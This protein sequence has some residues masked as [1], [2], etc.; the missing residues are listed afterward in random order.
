MVLW[1]FSIKAILQRPGRATLTLLSIVIG[2][3]ILVSVA[4]ATTTTR[5]AY[6]DMF[7]A[8]SGRSAL[9]VTAEGGGSFEEDLVTI[10]R[11]TPGVEAAVPVIRRMSKGFTEGR[12]ASVLVLGID[13][14]VDGA[15]RDLGVTARQSHLQEDGVLLEADFARGLGVDVGDKMRLLGRRGMMKL[16]VQGLASSQLHLASI[17]YVRLETAQALFGMPSEITAIQVVVEAGA[18][19][20][21]V[22]QAIAQRLPVGISVRPPATRTQLA[23]ETMLSAETGLKMTTGFSL[24]LA[25][26]VILNT[27]LM[28]VAERRRQLSMMRAIGATRG[29]ISRLIYLEG[30][31]IASVGVVLGILAGLG[32]GHLLILAL[33]KALLVTLPP[34]QLSWLTIVLAG[35]FGLGIAVLGAAIPARRAAQLSPQEGMVGAATRGDV[36]TPALKSAIPGALMILIALLLLL[37]CFRNW[38]PPEIAVGTSLL[39]LLGMVLLLSSWLDPLARFGV[40][41]LTPLVRAE[42]NL[43][44]RQ[45][46]RHRARSALTMGVLFV[47][48]ATGVG[49]S[50]ALLDNIQ[51]VANW[52]RQVIVGDFF[53]RA[54]LPDMSGN[55][56]ADVPASA[57]D[58]ARRVPGVRQVG[59]TTFLP[60][61]VADASVM[62]I[63]REFADDDPLYLDLKTGSD[64]SVRQELR[65]G[66]VVIGT[67]LAQRTGL[68][69][70]DD[71]ELKTRDG[72]RTVRIAGTANDYLFGGLTV[73]LQRRVAEDWFKVDNVSSFVVRLDK[74]T[75]EN[76]EALADTR[77]RLSAICQRHG[78]MLESQAELTGM[79]DRMVAGV[80]ACLYGILVLG[81]IVAAFGTVNTL[82]MNV[83]E[84]TRELGLLRIVAMTRGQIRKTILAQAVILAAIGLVPGVCAG[85][86]VSYLISIGTAPATGHPIEFQWHPAL[87][88]V[89]LI[90]SLA[91]VL[92]AAWIPAERAA[93]LRLLEA[94]QYE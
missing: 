5:A 18:D 3:A 48:S 45:V 73:C 90:A 94:L 63:V 32:G 11:Q 43:A 8:V 2:V 85:V 87:L 41:L 55:L 64:K 24:L 91:I 66:Q 88:V 27:F 62:V 6:R 14:D 22:R 49:M 89:S 67:V 21:A 65:D 75:R 31:G 72:T 42:A 60:A 10:V 51:D 74:E 25:M 33:S 38:L 26:F 79:I 50:S 36:E 69:L 57:G 54:M 1:N 47:A 34:V 40:W 77:Q 93:R 81:F 70:G 19:E 28:N 71:L 68:G 15:V 16:V 83:L 30:L 7:A 46:L 84:Q 44:H 13:P 17:A 20:K 76:A 59:A 52:Y 37:A 29:Q 56:S 39:F 80:N 23:D 78:V 86:A 9:E 92:L 82:T 35:F 12:K 4:V 58:E 53:I 61:T